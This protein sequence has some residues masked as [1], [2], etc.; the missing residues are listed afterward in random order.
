MELVHSSRLQCAT[1]I[2][3]PGHAYVKSNE[4]ADSLTSIDT[5]VGSSAILL[6]ELKS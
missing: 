1:S 3:V 5:V 2:F 4:R 6:A